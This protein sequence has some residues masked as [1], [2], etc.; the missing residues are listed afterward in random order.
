MHIMCMDIYI[1]SDISRLGRRKYIKK[2]V[3]LQ[4]LSIAQSPINE[5]SKRR[6]DIKN[7]TRKKVN[8]CGYMNDLHPMPSMH[9]DI[10]GG[11]F[12]D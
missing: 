12:V 10:A 9:S 5:K 7:L 6:K 3:S 1:Y 11:N 2:P 4:S 8:R